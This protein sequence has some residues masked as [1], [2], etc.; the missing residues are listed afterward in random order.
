[1]SLPILFLFLKGDLGSLAVFPAKAPLCRD[2][3]IIVVSID[4]L[5]SNHLGC[6]GYDRS[7]SPNVDE[8]A[9]EGIVF[10]NAITPRPKTGPSLASLLGANGYATAAFVSNWVL[11]PEFSDFDRYFD[12]YDYDFTQPELN[13]PDHF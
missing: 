1:M 9:R 10:E 6:Y 12:L 8:F 5:R 13:R 11:K 2:C 4:N 3:N 7:T